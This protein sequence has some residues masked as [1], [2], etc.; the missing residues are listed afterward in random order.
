M[1]RRPNRSPHAAPQPGEP[2]P[3][4]SG[5]IRRRLLAVSLVA[6]ALATAVLLAPTRLAAQF[7]LPAVSPAQ[8]PAQTQ[9]PVVDN[10]PAKAPADAV[11]QVRKLSD[12]GNFAEALAAATVWVVDRRVSDGDRAELL[13][14]AARNIARVDPARVDALYRDVMTAD[15]GP[16]LAVEAADLLLDATKHGVIEEGAFRRGHWSRG[17]IRVNV[18]DA[19]RRQV[20]HDL[21]PLLDST[22][23]RLR[24]AVLGAVR[25]ALLWQ[26]G[27]SQW[28]MTQY[29]WRLLSLTDVTEPP[30]YANPDLHPEVNARTGVPVIEGEPAAFAVPESWDD[31]ASDGERWR[32]VDAQLDAARDGI[33]GERDRIDRRLHYAQMMRAWYGVENLARYSDQIA[34]AIAEA[35][36]QGDGDSDTDG[37]SQSDG[38]ML[39]PTLGDDETIAQLATGIRRL[40]LPPEANY[41]AIFRELMDREIALA[42]ASREANP[43]GLGLRRMV[44][45]TPWQQ[46]GEVY[47]NRMQFAKAVKVA[48]AFLAI[49]TALTEGGQ[50]KA[51]HGRLREIVAPTGRIEPSRS[52]PAGRAAELEIRFR[53]A[54]RAEFTVYELDVRRY[55]ADAKRNLRDEEAEALSDW[56]VPE[57]M[58]QPLVVR[59]TDTSSQRLYRRLKAYQGDRVAGWTA[60]LQPRPGHF[61]RTVP[62]TTPI[63]SAG[64]Y[65]V[66]AEFGGPDA[67]S[68]GRAVDGNECWSVMWV[69][70]LAVVSKPTETGCLVY[71]SDALTGRPVA[72]ASV[73]AFGFGLRV[74]YDNRR[75]RVQKEFK[76][77][78]ATTDENGLVRFDS[79]QV[80]RDRMRW[81]WMIEATQ[82]TGLQS[83]RYGW[84]GWDDQSGMRFDA[85]RWRNLQTFGVTD[86]P[87]YKPG[88]TVQVHLWSGRAEYG[89][90]DSP[91]G[92]PATLQLIDPQGER[93]GEEVAATFDEFGGIGTE[94]ALPADAKLGAYQIRLRAAWMGSGFRYVTS[95]RV[96][97]YRKPEYEVAVE[98][99]SEP[100]SLGETVTATVQATYYAGGPVSQGTVRVKVTRSLDEDRWYPFQPWDW[101]YGRGYGLTGW[102]ANRHVRPGGFDGMRFGGLRG[103]WNRQPDELVLDTELDLGADG[104]ATIEIDT[105]IAREL[106][107]EGTHRYRIA[108]DVTDLSRRVVS[109]S[110]SV[111]VSSEA[112]EVGVWN[113]G[114]YGRAGQR[115]AFLITARDPNGQAIDG[116]ATIELIRLDRD[117]DD[118]L[119]RDTLIQDTVQTESGPLEGGE[120]SV[121]LIPKQPGLYEVRASVT[122]TV[123]RGDDAEQV[124]ERH[125]EQFLVRGDDL[126]S[127]RLPTSELRVVPDKQTYAVG[128][129][130]KLLVTAPRDG[131]AV[132]GWRIADGGSYA[133]PKVFAMESGAAEFALPIREVDQPNRFVE[134]LCVFGGEVLVETVPLIVPPVE[135]ALDVT[136]E[137]AK[138]EYK[139][140]ETADVTVTVTDPNGNPVE[141]SLAV[142]AYDR[143]LDALAGGGDGRDI[144]KQFWDWT[145]THY[146]RTTHNLDRSGYALTPRG[147]RAL[148]LL[149]AF[150]GLTDVVDEMQKTRGIRRKL[151]RAAGVGGGGFGGDDAML[152]ARGAVPLPASAPMEMAQESLTADFAADGLAAGRQLAEGGEAAPE[153]VAVREDFADTASWTRLVTDS[154]GRASA[155]IT[156]PD[157]L[158]DWSLRA[159]G[160]AAKLQVG[161]ASGSAR[162]SKD[163]LVRIQ[164]PRFLTET[165]RCVLTATVQNKSPRPR[166]AQVSF[167]LSGPIELGEGGRAET[168]IT[169]PARQMARVRLPIVAVGEGELRVQV[170]AISRDGDD[171]LSDATATTIPVQVHGIEKVETWAGV[172]RADDDDGRRTIDFT[173][174]EERKPHQT[175]LEIRVSPSLAGSIVDALPYLAEY[176][177]GC[178]EQTL[179]RFLPTVLVNRT[180]ADLGLSLEELSRSRLNPEQRAAA[181]S[182]PGSPAWERLPD[183]KADEV[184]PVFSQAT[185]DDMTRAGIERLGKM[186]NSDGGWGWFSGLRERSYPHT[187]AVVVHG[188]QQ[189][190]AADAAVPEPMLARGLA[191]LRGHR[192]GELAKLRNHDWNEANATLLRED[193]TKRRQ[194]AKSRA[195]ELDAFVQLLLTRAEA[196]D[197]TD[198][199]RAMLDYLDR[200]RTTLSPYGLAL[201]GMALVESEGQTERLRMVVRNVDQYLTVDPENATAYLDTPET[202]H[203]WR[204]Y[205]DDIEANAW[206]LKL[207]VRVRPDDARTSGLASYLLKNRRHATY[208]KSTRD[209]ALAVSALADYLRATDELH[210][211]LTA[212]VL[213]DGR[214]VREVRITRDTLLSF[215]GTVVVEGE[216]LTAGRHTVELRRKGTGPLYYGVSLA[217]FTQEPFITKAGL[218]TRVRRTLWHLTPREAS[219]DVAGGANA[220]VGMAYEAYDRR[221]LDPGQTL[222]SGELIEVELTLET[223]NDYEYLIIEDFKPAGCEAVDPQ[224]GYRAGAYVEFRE[225][226]TALF[227]RQAPRGTQSLRYR[228][229][230]EQPGDYSGL[231][232]QVRAMYAPEL[233][234][235]SDEAKLAVSEE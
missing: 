9:R 51:M 215:D 135:K 33:A 184:A 131:A 102:T 142:A 12:E 3:G 227:L 228:L 168:V 85:A 124:T 92:Q 200:D 20:L 42:K 122:A 170:T 183:R 17:G 233:R 113:R 172:V 218:E 68:D 118:Q 126:T 39:L 223:K 18:Q 193:P 210:P 139:P 60:D 53:N 74:D 153:P 119:T 93:V 159:W 14:L 162:T 19:D 174:P 77:L 80:P 72:D 185:V 73:E 52:Q 5:L 125:V 169:I 38:I 182:A 208:W 133:D 186:Q 71:V 91:A 65:L 137:T 190:A 112:F 195:S 29:G 35:L 120:A 231:P 117:G 70:E 204:W 89:N 40:T 28:A 141:T 226:R 166:E 130:A 235:N 136:I 134:V 180:L 57:Q 10:I 219:V 198:D 54:D 55:I 47:R 6:A 149:G 41:L 21:L 88:E 234:G 213:I 82:P 62:I 127:V 148:T 177:Y 178:T 64:A 216:A 79:G 202:W 90:A 157:N 181:D 199:S 13:E 26:R 152:M 201:L 145:R 15:P 78:A 95:V 36:E 143:S 107:G 104:T 24:E 147:G 63:Q 67:E 30:E 173:V 121:G 25:R 96:E 98:A 158:T 165:D 229:R 75:Q 123:G 197:A 66:K 115:Q 207:Y 111:L 27:D 43:N 221:A 7:D 163:L 196:G 108:A 171:M 32:W 48:R 110:G 34:R 140:G 105:R 31:A 206:A 59:Q 189:A 101:L 86:R 225:N 97:E 116:E 58:A 109:A 49:D 45:W 232:A 144:R 22:E 11:A 46:L 103:G 61:D 156:W 106:Y 217:N 100:Q 224:S 81:Q 154:D 211:D 194:P 164:T 220:P 214:P 209:T 155:A 205:G 188:L 160:V 84:L 176:P 37:L 4:R 179:N 151:G 16:L 44:S 94:F 87:I 191:W 175:R 50:R 132:L 230:T 1:A 212:T 69:S 167:E 56:L 23:G 76:E 192:A 83:D 150:G 128:D 2:Q 161:Q 8:P 222:P 187:T 129:T 138:A 146:P 203:W 114:G 99:P